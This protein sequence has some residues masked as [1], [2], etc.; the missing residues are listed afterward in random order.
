M[1]YGKPEDNE[2]PADK[3]KIQ[4]EK[5]DFKPSGKL[6][7]A[8]AE[9]GVGPVLKW[10]EPQDSRLPTKKWRLYVFKEDKQLDPY[11]IH[12]QSAYLFGRDRQVVD[13]PLDHP[14]CSKQHAVLQYRAVEVED[15]EG[16]RT[17]IVKPYLLDLESTNGSFVNGERLEA[18][19]Y[20]ELREKD[21][22]RFGMSTREFVILHE[23][24]AS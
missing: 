11:Y 2:P 13:I 1:V 9:S 15:E 21:L 17:K 3:P 8:S 7:T 19:R 6:N 5:P 10:T 14:S 16:N 4:K 24:S 20:Y 12:R 18:A 22:V 23:Q